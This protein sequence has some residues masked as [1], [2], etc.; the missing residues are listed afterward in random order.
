MEADGDDG[1]A[2]VDSGDGAAGAGTVADAG[3]GRKERCGD[4]LYRFD[5]TGKRSTWTRG[6]WQ[7]GGSV[8]HL[9]STCA[10]S[11]LTGRGR[12]G[13]VVDE[14]ASS[15]GL[16]VYVTGRISLRSRHPCSERGRHAGVQLLRFLEQARSAGG[17]YISPPPSAPPPHAPLCRRRAALPLGGHGTRRILVESR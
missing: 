16:A 11:L 12:N 8:G 4:S 15:V 10:V 2:L 1:M 6:W 13:L 9:T 14:S 3:D 7:P 17:S 5:E